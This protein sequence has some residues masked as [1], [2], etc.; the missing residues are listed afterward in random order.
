MALIVRDHGLIHP[1]DAL[2]GCFLFGEYLLGE[3]GEFGSLASQRALGRCQSPRRDA[4]GLRPLTKTLTDL[5]LRWRNASADDER[6]DGG[7]SWHSFGATAGC[8]CSIS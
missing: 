1:V 6:S 8:G 3:Q 2:L 4:S 7:R 5:H